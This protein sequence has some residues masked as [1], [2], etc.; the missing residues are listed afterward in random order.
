MAGQSKVTLQNWE[1]ISAEH[2]K[3]YKNFLAKA[4]KKRC[5]KK[6]RNFMNR[7]L[8][9]SIVSLRPLLQKIFSQV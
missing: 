8:N 1:K 4:D 3:L 6:F 5:L 9:K 2:Q 7:R